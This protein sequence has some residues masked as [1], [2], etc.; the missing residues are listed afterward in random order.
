MVICPDHVYNQDNLFMGGI[1][2]E[3]VP[4]GGPKLGIIH[5]LS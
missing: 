3:T 4:L 2:D 1:W 5:R